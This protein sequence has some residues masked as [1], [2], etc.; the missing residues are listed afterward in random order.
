MA[1]CDVKVVRPSAKVI[2]VDTAGD[3]AVVAVFVGDGVMF[4]YDFVLNE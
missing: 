1:G 3:D 4:E 2:V